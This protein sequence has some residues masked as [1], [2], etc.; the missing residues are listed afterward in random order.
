MDKIE[1]T[2]GTYSKEAQR[3]VLEVREDLDIHE[4]KIMCRRLAASLGYDAES[5]KEAFGSTN[6]KSNT[7]KMKDILKG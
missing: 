4:F 6:S 1:Y 3:V 2:R 7:D 5:I